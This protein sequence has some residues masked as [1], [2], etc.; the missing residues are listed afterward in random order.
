MSRRHLLAGLV[1]VSLFVTGCDDA[2]NVRDQYTDFARPGLVVASDTLR[3]L[4]LE[5]ILADELPTTSQLERSDDCGCYMVP[6]GKV[7]LE[8]IDGEYYLAMDTVGE[9]VSAA[10]YGSMR[11]AVEN[12][13]HRSIRLHGGSLSSWNLRMVATDLAWDGDHLEA[14]WLEMYAYGQVLGAFQTS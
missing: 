2:G 4:G 1:L 9:A 3:D 12:H 11:E 7:S 13:T 8:P 10:G 5:V 6:L 14:Q